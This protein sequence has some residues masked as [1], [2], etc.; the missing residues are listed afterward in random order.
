MP[1]HVHHWIGWVL[2]SA[3]IEAE[4]FEIDTVQDAGASAVILPHVSLR[5]V[6]CGFTPTLAG[7]VGRTG[8]S[9]RPSCSLPTGQCST[10][11]RSLNR[12]LTIGDAVRGYSI[13]RALSLTI[14]LQ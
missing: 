2:V 11:H 8:Q 6:F 4:D 12:A 7:R 10:L 13:R 14:R 3:R 1:S 5:C 9:G